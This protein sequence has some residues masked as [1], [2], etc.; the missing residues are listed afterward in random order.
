MNKLLQKSIRKLEV[1]KNSKPKRMVKNHRNSSKEMV[2]ELL[3]D[4]KILS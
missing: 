3:I 2:L 1:A 4:L